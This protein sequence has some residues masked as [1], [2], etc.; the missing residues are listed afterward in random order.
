MPLEELTT[1]TDLCAST[2]PISF[3]ALGFKPVP[4]QRR[5]R[6]RDEDHSSTAT[7]A[8]RTTLIKPPA[9]ETRTGNSDEVDG[10]CVRCSSAVLLLALLV[11]SH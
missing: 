3:V 8:L 9:A 4:R 11:R 1:S 7:T 5:S 10:Q 6:V 2:P